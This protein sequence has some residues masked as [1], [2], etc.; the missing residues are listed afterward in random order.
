M[1]SQ[2]ERLLVPD[3]CGRLKKY[4][5]NIPWP[6]IETVILTTESTWRPM[7]GYCFETWFMRILEHAGIKIEYGSGDTLV[8]MVVKTDGDDITLQLKT[9]SKATYKEGK[10]IGY[11]LHKTHGRERMP[12]NL[13]DP[14]DFPDF[15]VGKHPDGV[16]I[17][18]RK[19][20][21]RHPKHTSKLHNVAK[22][23]WKDGLNDFQKIG[24]KREIRF[25]DFSWQNIEFPIIGSETQ[26]SDYDILETLLRN[27]NF[28]LLKQNVIGNLREWHFQQL[29]ISKNILVSR[30]GTGKEIK[31]DFL[32]AGGKKIQVKGVTKR[33]SNSNR[34]CVEVK[35]SH[36]RVPKR[37]YK[38]GS[39]DFLVIV[40]DPFE[41]PAAVI[42]K[43]IDRTEFNCIIIPADRLPIHK[44]SKEWGSPYYKDIFCFKFE[45]VDI[46]AL[47]L[48]KPCLCNFTK[49]LN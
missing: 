31:V 1:A 14:N 33:I 20:L 12:D 9:H 16:I 49:N 46:N 3:M 18:P 10:S 19:D 34:M 26:L 41:I 44:R 2:N 47:G 38:S 11:D 45:D 35:G 42:P 36:G 27:E 43:N 4:V 7:R 8:D 22:F 29:A 17:K 28:R 40:L 13:Y 30:A 5:G 24:I 37:L 23:E 39:F 25:P 21:P 6:V 15:L 32:L 48:L